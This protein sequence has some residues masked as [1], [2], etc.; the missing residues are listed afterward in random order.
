[1]GMVQVGPGQFLQVGVPSCGIFKLNMKSSGPSVRLLTIKYKKNGNDDFVVATTSLSV[2]AAATFDLTALFPDIIFNGS[3]SI[4]IESPGGNTQIHDLYVE[5]SNEISNEAEISAFKIPGQVG[6]EIITSASGTIAINVALGTLLTSVVPSSIVISSYATISPLP[7]ASQ[8]FSGQKEVSYTVTAQDTITIKTWKVVVTE[9]ASTEKEITAFKLSESQIGNA[10]INP[11]DT[12]ITVTMPLGTIVTSIVPAILNISSGA[13]LAPLATEVRDFSVPVAY[14][15]TAQD[16]SFKTWTIKVVFEPLKY[17]LNL[18]TTGIGNVTLNPAGGEYVEGTVV[19]LT[20]NSILGSV[21]Q[22]WSGNL[23]GTNAI[24]TVTMNS[25][26]DI[27]ASFASDL[28]PDFNQVVGFAAVT[29]D[30]FTGP[31][32]GGGTNGDTVII[33]GPAEFGKLCELLYN[34]IRYKSYS[35][36]PLTIILEEGIYDGTGGTG[37]VWG[38]S[39]LTIQEQGN[40]TII[41]RKNVVLKFGINVKRSWNIIIRNLYFQ[42]YYDDGINIGEPETHHIWVDHCTVGHPTTMPS[43]TEHPDGGIDIKNG[44]SYVTVSWTLYRNSWKTGLVGH[45]DSNGGTDIGRLKVTYYCDYFYNT[46]SRNPRVRFGE[47]HVLNCLHEKVMLY[48]IVA[49]NSAYVFAENNFFLNTDWPMYA[50]RTSA[51]FKLVYGNNTDNAYTSKTGNLPCAGLKQTGNE[52][53]DS[54]LP[55][56]SS[57][58]NPAML[59]PGGRSIKFDSLNSSSV[60]DPH[61]YYPYNAL[62]ASTVRTLIPLFAGADKVDFLNST[63]TSINCKSVQKHVI[64]CYPNPVKE[65]LYFSD[66]EAM[67]MLFDLTGKKIYQGK[68][69]GQLD[70][71]STGVKAGTYLIKTVAKNSVSTGK[72]IVVK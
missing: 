51:D 20:A 67:V 41:G 66:S 63:I 13:T 19:T 2:Q 42:D 24:E 56:I 72:L 48:G 58:I 62:P 32:T 26:K 70:I 50:D 65:I 43:N 28:Q 71:K 29:A 25:A 34:R 5:A 3:D 52:Y 40:L 31:T 49:A 44:A 69:A 35:N 37:S 39:M 33:N 18:T 7:S 22:G 64:L 17:K 59:N 68:P 15:V 54:G 53:D 36:R 9:V 21:F 61:T 4:R 60:F 10:V 6:N 55:V 45:S 23:S 27:H 46:N 1:M 11:T 12:T 8:D 38:N 47:V 14:K 16:N 30:G 57:M